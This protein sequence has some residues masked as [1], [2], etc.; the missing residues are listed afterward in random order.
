MIKRVSTENGE[1]WAIVF[2]ES[3]SLEDV[4]NYADGLLEI[5]IT[6]TNSDTWNGKEHW[7]YWALS[8]LQQFVPT[9]DTVMD[10]EH[11]LKSIGKIKKG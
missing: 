9:I 3:E 8:L 2:H 6:A 5:I 4:R 11:H 10:Y 1:C 7:S